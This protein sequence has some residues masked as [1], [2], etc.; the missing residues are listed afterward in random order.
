MKNLATVLFV[1]FA[2]N[3]FGQ[4]I[5]SETAQAVATTFLKSKGNDSELVLVHKTSEL[6]IF[7]GKSSGFVIVSASDNVT[8]ILGYS[9]TN[10]FDVTNTPPAV[11]QILEGYSKEIAY[12]VSEQVEVKSVQVQWDNLKNGIAP[13]VQKSGKVEPM[14][15]TQWGQGDQTNYRWY[16]DS[17]PWD[18]TANRNVIAGC[19]A[20]AM[21][22]IMKYWNYPSK[23][24]GARSYHCNYEVQGVTRDYGILSANFGNTT[25]NYSIMPNKLSNQS[26]DA[27]K[28]AIA[29]LIYHCGVAINTKY[30]PNLSLAGGDYGAQVDVPDH[31]GNPKIDVITALQR[32][33]G[34]AGG[35]HQIEKRN[36]TETEWISKIKEELNAGRPIIYGSSSHSYI[37]DGY[38][39]ADMFHLNF[40]W[41]GSC[42]G[43]FHTSSIV[44]TQGTWSS[45]QTNGQ[46]A[47][48][49]IRPN[50]STSVTETK[51]AISIKIYPNPTE[52]NFIIDC[53][54]ANTIKL[55]DVLGKEVLTQ[56]V[57]VKT[58]INISH[59]PNG[60]YNVSV[61]SE[62]KIVGNSKIV[63][64]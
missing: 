33:F 16:N 28:S 24:T 7:N 59:L 34:Y 20:V 60:M 26:T 47:I 1:L 37:C 43:Y 58:E 49:N 46:D 32:Y 27:E 52:N 42:N 54:N 55:Y 11:Q 62:G 18:N 10:T 9:T 57:N 39:E 19:N 45:N 44:P 38:D 21:A 13:K 31:L 23:G 29:Q 2:S 8:P 35:I 61:F 30:S 17:C 4:N 15:T 36:F 40:G 14:I 6:Y 48:L 63:K 25:Y 53:E 3:L 51:S 5:N 12:I 56:T 64:Q 50:G 22:Q 41:T